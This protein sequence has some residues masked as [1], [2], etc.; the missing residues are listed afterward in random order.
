MAEQRLKVESGPPEHVIA[1]AQ[2]PAQ[3]HEEPAKAEQVKEKAQQAAAPAAEKAQQ[4][5]DKARQAA[6]P[7]K[8]K[9][10]AVAGE[11]KGHA[12]AAA[13]Q[14]KAQAAAQVDEKSTQVGQQI[15][16]QGEA[17]EGVAGELRKQ[18]KDGPAK[19]AEQAAEKVKDVGDYLEQADGEKLVQAAQDVA[20]ENPAAAA[21][22]GAAAG[23]V[24]GRVIKASSADDAPPDDQSA[25]R[26]GGE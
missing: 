21:A 25:P 13:E 7:A 2:T 15:G 19:V 22:V 8:E 16:A 20:R 18:G 10:R 4:V 11:A 23:F 14:A 6:A 5:K 24:A 26:E 3:S 12:Q 9:A 17:L 1:Q